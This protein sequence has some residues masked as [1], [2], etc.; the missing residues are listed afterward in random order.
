MHAGGE[1]GNTGYKY[2]KVG[3]LELIKDLNKSTVAQA[4]TMEEH[5][6]NNQGQLNSGCP[7]TDGEELV[8]AN[9]YELH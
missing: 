1:W 7:F 3:P 4:N 8:W 2:G 5:M 9:D 6:R